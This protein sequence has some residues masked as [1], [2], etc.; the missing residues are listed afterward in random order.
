MKGLFKPQNLAKYMGDP[1][2]IVFRSSW[3]LKFMSYLDQH[4]DV[5]YWQSEEL[6]IPYKSP[7]DGRYHR[8]FPDFLVKKK[9]SDGV[10]KT[11]IIE[12]KPEK[13]TKPPKHPGKVTKRYINEVYTWGVNDSKWKAA[14]E[15]CA[16]RKWSFYIFTEKELGIKW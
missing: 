1:T 12:I 13:Q 6:F 10:I 3:E 4:T 16:D 9:E 7:V 8:Y 15:Y 2:K 11:A 14:R 5:I